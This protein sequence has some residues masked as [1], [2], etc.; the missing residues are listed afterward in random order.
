MTKT[1]AQ[2]DQD[3]S[4]LRP[5]CTVEAEHQRLKVLTDAR[6]LA[7][8]SMKQIGYKRFFHE[9]HPKLDAINGSLDLLRTGLLQGRPFEADGKL[10]SCKTIGARLYC[11]FILV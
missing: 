6:R 3:L 8:S 7:I 4:Q 10:A 2:L 9:L 1:I 5:K 11:I